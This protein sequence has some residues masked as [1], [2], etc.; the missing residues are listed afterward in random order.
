MSMTVALLGALAAGLIL[1]AGALRGGVRYTD[2]FF[3][4]LLLHPG[5]QENLLWSIQF[6]FALSAT[7]AT[8]FFSSG[9]PAS[10][11]SGP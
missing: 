10:A 3:P 7:M 2:A 9:P 11:R 6:G 1:V 5:H 4:I 8:A